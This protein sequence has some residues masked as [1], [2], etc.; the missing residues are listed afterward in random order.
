MRL[1][2]IGII[3]TRGVPN[4]YGGFEQLAEYLS[5]GL[6]AKKHKVTV[7]NSHTHPYKEKEWNDVNIIHCFDPEK[8]IGTAGQFVYDLNCILDARKRKFDALVFLGYTSSSIW[9]PFYPKKTAII[10]NMDGLE[11]K[12]TKYKK[13]VQQFLKYAEKL[14]IYHSDSLIADSTAIQSYINAN[15]ARPSTFIAYGAELFTNQQQYFLNQFNLTSNNYCMLMARMEPENNI[16]MILD[17]FA[18]S[19][20]SKK[21]IVIGN[22]SNRFGTYI[23]NKFKRIENIIFAG[24]IYDAEII[25]SLKYY[26]AL[27]FHG[28]SVGGTNPSLLEAMASQA[29]IAANDNEFNRAVLEKNAYYFT[30]ADEVKSIIEQQENP[31]IRNKFILNNVKEIKKTYNWQAITD[32]YEE[33]IITTYLKKFK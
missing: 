18:K 29:V 20:T 5:L 14:A 6:A 27:Y 17:G 7:Y 19:S 11:W 12:R 30:S 1:L 33:L 21:M 8:N 16:E 25:H 9:W 31:E 2:N 3:G 10:S 13:P 22:T 28:H 26:S 4:R 24:P 15:Y 32:A 23:V